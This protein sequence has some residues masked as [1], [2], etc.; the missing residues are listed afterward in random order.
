MQ[1]GFKPDCHTMSKADFNRCV[2]YVNISHSH[3]AYTRKNKVDLA[4][5]P[6]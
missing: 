6:G 5:M 3:A 4:A 2:E 1:A